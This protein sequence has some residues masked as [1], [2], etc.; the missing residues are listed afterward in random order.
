[1]L[2]DKP[3]SGAIFLGEE[4]EGAGETFLFLKVAREHGLEGMVSKRVDLAT[5][6][7]FVVNANELVS[8]KVARYLNAAVSGDLEG[9]WRQ[10]H[11]CLSERAAGGVVR[12]RH[13]A[14]LCR[15][16]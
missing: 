7:D 13:S 5:A 11:G 2:I 8:T 14:F 16:L 10:L 6:D 4:F 3:T 1:V 12:D 9:F 15:L